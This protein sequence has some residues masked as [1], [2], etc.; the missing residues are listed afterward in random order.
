[1]YVRHSACSLSL[2]LCVCVVRF[3][4]PLTPLTHTRPGPSCRP[5]IAHAFTR[6]LV[7]RP[8]CLPFLASSSRCSARADVTVGCPST[9]H[10]PH[11]VQHPGPR[12]QDPISL[13]A[14]LSLLSLLPLLPCSLLIPSN[15]FALQLPPGWLRDYVQTSIASRR[16]L[17]HS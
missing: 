8:S 7:P 15:H 6:S 13:L 11:A 10:S 4:A 17:P 9:Y 3:I 2:F 12:T 16:I 1:M 14:L 5:W